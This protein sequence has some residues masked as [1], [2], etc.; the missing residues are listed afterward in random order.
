MATGN[1]R[2]GKRNYARPT[3]PTTG[4]MTNAT[5]V[6]YVDISYTA[7]NLGPAATSFTFTGTSTTGTT[8]SAT[9]TTSPT[10]VSGFSG[11]AIYA[12]NISGVNYNGAGVAFSI[13]NITIPAQYVLQSTYNSS[14]TYTVESG[15]TKIAAF[16]ISGSGGGARGANT[17]QNNTAGGAGGGGG[18]PAIAAFQEYSVTAG[19]TVTITVGASGIGSTTV[20]SGGNGGISKVTYGGVDIVTANGGSGG[21]NGAVG[22]TGNGAGGAGGA[23][24]NATTNISGNTNVYTVTGTTGGSGSAGNGGTGGS[25]NN[26]TSN[27]TLTEAGLSNILPSNTSFG[28]GGGGT[29]T[30]G[31][32]PG[33]GGAGAGGGSNSGNTAGGSGTSFGGGGGGSTGNG[34]GGGAGGDG[35]AG[36]IILYVK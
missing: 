20:N 11:G 17:N 34:Q 15:K 14:G 8:V 28:S 9:L 16:V 19:Q 29:G 21:T 12:G 26:Q 6:G 18:G 23:G 33:N 2:G 10:A 13:G 32:T 36:Q 25:G 5:T 3:S 27:A 35:S 22:T 7:S 24:G 4:S 31:G 1:I 30:L